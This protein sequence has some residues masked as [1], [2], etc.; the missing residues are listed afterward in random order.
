MPA[1]LAILRERGAPLL[2]PDSCAGRWSA[3][4]DV[5]AEGRIRV[6]VGGVAGV[7]ATARHEVVGW[8]RKT[9]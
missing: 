3:M 6:S 7:L 9:H 2:A 8:P 4:P 1:P 5:S